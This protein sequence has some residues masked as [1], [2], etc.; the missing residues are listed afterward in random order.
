VVSSRELTIEIA[1]DQTYYADGKYLI[2][3]PCYIIPD[4]SWLAFAD[5][6]W[7]LPDSAGVLAVNGHRMWV[8]HTA[9]GDGSYYVESADGCNFGSFNVDAGMYAIIPLALVKEL[10]AD[11]DG[12]V[13]QLYGTVHF[14]DG[15]MSVGSCY[16]NTGGP[17]T[18]TDT[19]LCECGRLEDECATFD[20]D[21]AE[22]DDRV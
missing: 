7:K 6:Y 9:H 14:N 4:S 15:D 2:T 11:L 10:D 1:R 21:E 20:D 16:V 19:G 8:G 22:H 17:D 5:L 18:P 3:D 13:T 12:V